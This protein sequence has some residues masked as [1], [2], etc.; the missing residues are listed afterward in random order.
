MFRPSLHWL[1]CRLSSSALEASS[2]VM[3]CWNITRLSA[4]GPSGGKNSSKA[5]CVAIFSLSKYSSACCRLFSECG[6]LAAAVSGLRSLP[7]WSTKREASGCSPAAGGEMFLG[8]EIQLLYSLLLSAKFPN[9]AVLSSPLTAALTWF[10]TAQTA[11]MSHVVMDLSMDCC[12]MKK[13]SST[14]VVVVC[15]GSV[16]SRLSVSRMAFS[17]VWRRKLCSTQT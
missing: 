12:R 3:Q 7:S 8:W 10:T 14:S 6:Q 2:A 9:N 13:T 16:G 5:S 11:L 17:A 15:S 4:S 1:E